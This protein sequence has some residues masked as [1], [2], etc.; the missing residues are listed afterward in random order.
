M[1]DLDITQAEA[2]SLMAMEKKAVDQKEWLFPGPAERIVIP[3]TS[4]DKR[5]N[6]LLDVTR[7][8]IRLTKATFQNRAHV[9]IILY[10]LDIDGAPHRNPDGQEIPCPHLHVYREGFG[11][12]WAFPAPIDKFPNTSDLFSTLYAFME[13]CNITQPPTIQKG[14]FS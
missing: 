10:R 4:L 1:A 2:A 9:V 12:K 5:E 6:F 7:Y 3:V 14:L 13:H 8:Q 11:D